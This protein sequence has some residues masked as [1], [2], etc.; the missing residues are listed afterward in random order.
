V[1]ISTVT[2]ADLGELLPLMR[3]YCDFYEV[4][5]SDD[6]LLALSR[7]LISDSD[8][9][10]FQ[11]LAR[12]DAADAVGF[13]TVFWS[14]TTL[15]AAPIAVM[16]DLFVRPEARGGG[17]A[18]A[19]IAECLRRARERGCTHLEWATAEDNLRAQALYDRV[20]GRREDHWVTYSL[21]A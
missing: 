14:W 8:C 2:E 6:A 9:H 12:G 16:N 1:R 10:G 19:L 18:E 17:F 13:A 3:A 4:E 11:L 21:D 5:P 15:S 20:G 7:A